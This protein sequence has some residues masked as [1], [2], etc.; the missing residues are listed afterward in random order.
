MRFV[1]ILIVVLLAL[2]F[3]GPTA[4][5][6][7][8]DQPAGDRFFEFPL[9]YFSQTIKVPVGNHGAASVAF[10][11]Q[12][13][14]TTI[15]GY[16]PYEQQM[17]LNLATGVIS[18]TNNNPPLAGDFQDFAPPAA[19]GDYLA[20]REHLQDM[21]GDV[22]WIADNLH[23]IAAEER[24][25]IAELIAGTR[26]FLTNALEATDRQAP[27]S[28]RIRWAPQELQV[29]ADSYRIS[30]E[31]VARESR[32]VLVEHFDQ[33][34]NYLGGRRLTIEA[35][36]QLKTVGFAVSEQAPVGQSGYIA[37]KLLPR[38]GDWTER[39]AEDAATVRYHP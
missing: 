6:A 19:G 31:L 39:L 3:V 1:K 10:L 23:F 36:Y 4:V 16:G 8:H 7:D 18:Y 2:G 32:D 20:Y 27:E 13:H 12:N 22:A 5:A 37:V 21:L 25:V 26:A 29:G 17:I 30:L 15:N 33:D 35:G 34:W 14:L 11:D 28:I 24:P 9:P 38:D